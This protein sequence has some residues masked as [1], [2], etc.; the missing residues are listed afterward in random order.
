MLNF[1]LMRLYISSVFMF[2]VFLDWPDVFVY[3][4]LCHGPLKPDYV[5]SAYNILSFDK[6][7]PNQSWYR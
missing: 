1:V 6:S 3:M 7:I 2:C 5:S 4:P